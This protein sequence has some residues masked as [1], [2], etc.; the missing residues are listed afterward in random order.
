MKKRV[1]AILLALAMILSISVVAFGDPGSQR[2]PNR[3]PHLVQEIIYIT[4]NNYIMT[5]TRD[6][7][8]SQRPPS[9]PPRP[10]Q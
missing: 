4:Y 1:F 5:A 7:P 8:G 2:P 3:P 10:G 6:D 9:R